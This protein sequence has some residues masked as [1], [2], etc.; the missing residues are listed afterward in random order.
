M[1]IKTWGVFLVIIKDLEKNKR[2]LGLS[3]W[4]PN[5]ITTLKRD[6]PRRNTYFKDKNHLKMKAKAGGTAI[7]QALQQ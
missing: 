4:I 7:T 6:T 5:P 2:I 3:R 1:L